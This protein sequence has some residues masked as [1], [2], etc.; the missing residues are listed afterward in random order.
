MPSNRHEMVEVSLD[1]LL[2]ILEGVIRGE[3]RRQR[4]LITKYGL[5]YKLGIV[6]EEGLTMKLGI[7][8]VDISGW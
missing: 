8:E 2:D 3:V 7:R 5:D 4:E 6:E 1:W